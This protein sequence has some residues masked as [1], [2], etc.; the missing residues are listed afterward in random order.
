[1][2]SKFTAFDVT[3]G[4]C[5]LLELD[6][7]N[8]DASPFRALVDTGNHATQAAR[9]LETY[10][11]LNGGGPKP[12]LDVV[13]VTHTDAD[14]LNGL[15]GVL[16]LDVTIPE[17]WLPYLTAK[18][19]YM[20]FKDPVAVAEVAGDLVERVGEAAIVEALQRLTAEEG[21]GDRS[22]DSQQSE[23]NAYVRVGSA[24]VRELSGELRDASEKLDRI[25]L[26]EDIEP[27]DVGT[28]VGQLRLAAGASQSWHM[29]TQEE[30]DRRFRPPYFWPQMLWFPRSMPMSEAV[31]W[32]LENDRPWTVGFARGVMMAAL[33]SKA[34]QVKEAVIQAC[35]KRN[36]MT[37]RF[38]EYAD[39]IVP[40]QPP[41]QPP[42]PVGVINATEIRHIP[43]GID[44]STVLAL[45]TADNATNHTSLVLYAQETERYPAVLLSADSDFAFADKSPYLTWTTSMLITA[46]HHGSPKNGGLAQL[47]QV[48]QKG[49]LKLSSIWVRSDKR[50]KKT[51][52][53]PAPWWRV[54]LNPSIR[55]DKYCTCCAGSSKT[56]TNHVMLTVNSS[57]LWASTHQPCSC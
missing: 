7:Q 5:F 26:R 45:I 57:G 4:N 38:F 33:C 18:A 17:L 46:P 54:E 2:P 27:V 39:R 37:V 6:R 15:S 20:A 36:D 29:R 3:V 13:T 14:H 48:E 31:K 49:N 19:T 55:V 41:M 32:L 50:Q 9:F 16:A 30:I 11:G 53:C 21:E 56:N 23:S 47:Y 34:H 40:P 25:Y 44:P 43:A 35:Q 28:L 24:L 12:I 22:D 10:L 42:L 8:H 1:M 52:T 51:S